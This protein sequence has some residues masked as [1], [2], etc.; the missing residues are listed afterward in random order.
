MAAV[1]MA[2]EVITGAPSL[3]PD[4]LDVAQLALQLTPEAVSRLVPELLHGELTAAGAELVALAKEAI[5][6]IIAHAAAWAVGGITGLL[7]GAIEVR[8]GIAAAQ[9]IAILANLDAALLSGHAVTAVAVAYGGTG[10]G[11]AQTT[12][13]ATVVTPQAT[14]IVYWTTVSSVPQPLTGAGALVLADGSI[15]FENGF[16]FCGCS[17]IDDIAGGPP[18]P[19]ETFERYDPAANVWRMTGPT[20]AVG[21]AAGWVALS[22][23]RVLLTGWVG[24][25]TDNSS[26]PAAELFDPRTNQWTPV[27][28]PSVGG[29]VLVKQA[30]GTPLL[31]G[32][33]DA[34][35]QPV[36]LVQT[37]SPQV[38][39]WRTVGHLIPLQLNGGGMAATQLADGRVFVWG[40]G[41]TGPGSTQTVEGEVF[42]PSTATSTTF[43]SLSVNGNPE[44]V[45]SLPDGEVALAALD[46]NDTGRQ[47]TTAVFDPTTNAWTSPR[48]L[49]LGSENPS[50]LP[51]ADGTLLAI[52]G[53]ASQSQPYTDLSQCYVNASRKV[54]DIDPLTGTGTGLPPIGIACYDV[55]AAQLADGRVLVAG[56]CPSIRGG[57]AFGPSFSMT[58]ELLGPAAQ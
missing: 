45:W 5:L 37:F 31:L 23:G 4:G 22:D 52:G 1:G 34:Q 41:A 43:P 3:R 13:A 54:I 21:A 32:G 30:D 26:R 25:A 8:L 38:G 6:A 47:L 20:R 29:G 50:L 56:G 28:A 39:A 46:L 18:L 36:W 40:A 27:G 12:G 2:L 42:D 7:P 35:Q 10:E 57:T 24:S 55:A 17:G 51:L 48:T 19:G 15:L 33:S 49:E 58:V 44:S 14:P 16:S 9:A 11:A 53:I